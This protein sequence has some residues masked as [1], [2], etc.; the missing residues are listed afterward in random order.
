VAK[1]LKLPDAR[2]WFD[3]GDE[4]NYTQHEL[5]KRGRQTGEQG[6]FIHPIITLKAFASECYLKSLITLEGSSPPE[7]HHLLRLFDRLRPASKDKIEKLWNRHSKPELDKWKRQFPK[8]KLPNNLRAALDES[9]EAFVHWR[10][11]HTSS[12]LQYSAMAFPQYVRWRIVELTNWG[13][14][15]PHP[16]APFNPESE[17]I[18]RKSNSFEGGTTRGPIFN[19]QPAPLKPTSTLRGRTNRGDSGTN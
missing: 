3:R 13:Y 7:I 18:E 16:L 2:E 8:D 5:H 6:L 17:L 19:Y 9:A 15:P 14:D 1:T 10:Y 4:F 12:R 11:V